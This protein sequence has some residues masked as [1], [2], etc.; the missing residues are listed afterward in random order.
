M[1]RGRKACQAGD[2]CQPRNMQEVIY[3]MVQHSAK[4]ARTIADELGVRLGY[5][6]DA[7]NPDREDLQFQARHLLPLMRI[8]GNVLALKF[9]AAELGYMVVQLPDAETTD[10]TIY[11]SFTESVAK[12]G[13][14]GALIRKGL[15]D[16]VL[17]AA[18][19]RG[20][21]ESV[22]SGMAVIAS[23]KPAVMKLVKVGQS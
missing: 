22:D 20:I 19:A 21:C 4:D 6:L 8:T 9:L 16:K 14:T 3:C 2:R 23:V 15:D 18:E 13:E 17:T 11:E 7:S 12:L 5:L 1:T 10:A